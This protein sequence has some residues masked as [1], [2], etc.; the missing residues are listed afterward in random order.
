MN[1]FYKM[2]LTVA[3]LGI[4]SW[5]RTFGAP[6]DPVNYVLEASSVN[7]ALGQAPG[8]RISVT[9]VSPYSLQ[10]AIGPGSEGY[11]LHIEGPA[12]VPIWWFQT[13][14]GF[15]ALRLAPGQQ[16]YVFGSA[17]SYVDSDPETFDK[18]GVYT[19]QYCDDWLID[20]RLRAICSNVLQVHVSR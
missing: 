9:N 20:G 18:P 7:I 5:T 15:Y 13:N 1:R 4:M 6:P 10:H 16:R 19:V 11:L 2:M 3:I 8:F 14:M 17:S 12:R